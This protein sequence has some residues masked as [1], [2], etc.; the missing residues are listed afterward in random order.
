MKRVLLGLGGILAEALADVVFA[1]A[2]LD[3]RSAR[4]M[5]GRLRA[6]H[7]LAHPFRG[8]PAVDGDALADLLGALALGLRCFAPAASLQT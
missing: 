2:P 8:E 7:L 3:R 5:I 1:A 6:S 4:A